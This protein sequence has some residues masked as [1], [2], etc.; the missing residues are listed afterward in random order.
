M[1]PVTSQL[2]VNTTVSFSDFTVEITAGYDE[3][4]EPECFAALPNMRISFNA[5]VIDFC[6]T[7]TLS[8]IKPVELPFSN[9]VLRSEGDSTNK[10][11]DLN[12]TLLS[13]FES[14]HPRCPITLIRIYHQDD[15]GVATYF[16]NLE[17][18]PYGDYEFENEMYTFKYNTAFPMSYDGEVN[19]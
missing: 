13:M 16:N 3:I 4:E 7:Q 1:D 15:D 9:N 5:T 18:F 14:S 11:I 10:A 17:Q 19:F 12:A 2:Q 8:I 6:E